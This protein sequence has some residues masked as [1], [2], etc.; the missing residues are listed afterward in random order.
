MGRLLILNYGSPKLWYQRK[1]KKSSHQLPHLS[2]FLSLLF[3][4]ARSNWTFLK[5]KYNVK[6]LTDKIA[7]QQR[8]S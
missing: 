1:E 8:G 2:L 7:K 6:N 4:S 5:I 3:H